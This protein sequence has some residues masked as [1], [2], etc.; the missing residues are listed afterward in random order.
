LKGHTAGLPIG[1]L[2]VPL[3]FFCSKIGVLD[4]RAVIK[5]GK[6]AAQGSVAGV[7]HGKAKGK[8]VAMM[9]GTGWKGQD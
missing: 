1:E 3:K 2:E 7:R 6:K 5:I 8:K 9:E 4:L